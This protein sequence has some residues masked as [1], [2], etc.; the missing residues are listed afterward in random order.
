MDV[1]FKAMDLSQK[2]IEESRTSQVLRH[3][4]KALVRRLQQRGI[5]IIHKVYFNVT[6]L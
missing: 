6:L 1:G 4:R 3:G 2:P 5:A